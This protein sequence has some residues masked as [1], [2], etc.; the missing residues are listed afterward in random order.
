ME[1]VNGRIAALEHTAR[2][3]ETKVDELA[4]DTGAQLREIAASMQMMVRMEERQVAINA[5]LAEGSRTM[6][7]QNNRIA[8]LEAAIPKRADSRLGDLEREMP[9]IK[10]ATGDIRRMK[11]LVISAVVAAILA[12]VLKGTA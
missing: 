7:E 10:E 8:A 6:Q 12:L 9:Q 3:T 4:R 1:H 11:W 2:R 5:R